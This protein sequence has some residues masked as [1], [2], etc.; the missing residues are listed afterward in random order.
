MRILDLLKIV[1]SLY[2][3]G[4]SIHMV[5]PPGIGKSDVTHEI[6]SIL[7]AHFEEE[8]G[9]WD[10]LLPTYDAPDLRGFL[11][12]TKDANGKATSFF[13]RPAV[14]PSDDYLK[15]HPRGIFV[16][17]ERNA[18]DMPTLKAAAPGVLWK[19]FGDHR[20]PERWIIISASNRIADRA[21]V[22]KPPTHLVN[23]E[24]TI[25]IQSDPVSYSVWAE[26]H[27]VHPMYIAFAKKFPG[28]VFANEVPK[29]DG[30]YCTARSFTAAANYHSI[31][32]GTD[33]DG[34][35]NMI[36][37]SD[38]LT[39]EVV[40]GHVGQGAAATMFSYFKLADQLPEIEEVEKD[41]T[42]A[43]C[44]TS[45][46]AGY[47]AAQMCLHYVKGGNVDALWTYCERL[48]K[49]IQVATAKSMIERSGGALL[50]SKKLAAWISANRALVVNSMG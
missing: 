45:L 36:L 41:P 9:Y 22:T 20:L 7:S 8:F 10:I 15:A 30:P 21:G 27:G 6:R 42:K 16:I 25:E 43:K 13:T 49:E 5:G 34:K 24:V 26:R 31:V 18:G 23:R 1:P 35:I 12:P 2:K 28:V 48:P 44:P 50:N 39:Q 11:V 17:D 29:A 14:L 37:P 47:A 40:S 19:R 38:P 32:A 46:D 33:D 3:A 4:T